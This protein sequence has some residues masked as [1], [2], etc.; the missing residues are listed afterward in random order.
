[1][2]LRFSVFKALSQVPPK[3]IRLRS[4][5]VLPLPCKNPF[6]DPSLP[7]SHLMPSFPTARTS[8]AAWMSPN[9]LSAPCIII[10]L[11]DLLVT[12]TLPWQRPE[13]KDDELCFCIPDMLWLLFPRQ[14]ITLRGSHS[15]SPITAFHPFWP[16]FRHMGIWATLPHLS[17]RHAPV[18]APPL[19]AGSHLAPRL[20]CSERLM[21]MIHPK[22]FTLLIRF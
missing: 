18:P 11:G 14:Q 20:L 15:P 6:G 9:G 5:W 22:T 1:M 8:G 13:N 7:A 10:T 3:Q 21:L 2:L 12:H 17:C 19:A 16:N 4:L